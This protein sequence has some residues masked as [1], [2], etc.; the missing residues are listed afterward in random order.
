VEED[1]RV[2]HR[3]RVGLAQ[4][5]RFLVVQLIHICL[6]FRFDMGVTFVTNYF[7]VRGDIPINSDALLVTDLQMCS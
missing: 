7:S 4:W 6:N 1:Q 2:A 5:V 3:S